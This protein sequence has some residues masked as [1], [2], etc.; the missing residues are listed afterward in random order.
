MEKKIK[1]MMSGVIVVPFL[2]VL[3]MSLKIIGVVLPMLVIIERLT[4][5][6]TNFLQFFVSEHVEF[7]INFLWWRVPNYLQIVVAIIMGIIFFRIG[8][9][10]WKLLRSYVNM[11]AIK[12]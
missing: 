1:L 4:G 7:T 2:A 3:G 5:L 12:N 8:K 6:V 9:L 10:L 11:F